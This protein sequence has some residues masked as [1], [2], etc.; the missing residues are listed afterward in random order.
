MPENSIESVGLIK[1][2]SI[3]I[4]VEHQKIAVFLNI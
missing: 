2:E 4:G 3:F 1:N